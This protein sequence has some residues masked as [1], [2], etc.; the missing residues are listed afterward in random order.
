MEFPLRKLL[1]RLALA[2]GLF[3]LAVPAAANAAAVGINVPGGA[4]AVSKAALAGSTGATTGRVFLI[5]PGGSAPD[6]G[7]VANYQALISSFNANGVKPVIVVTGTTAP[8]DPAAYASYVG[9]LARDYGSSVAAWEI[10]NEPDEAIWWGKSGG[11]PAVYAQ[12]LKDVY[13]KVHP[14]APVFVGGLTGNDYSFLDNLYQALGG[15]SAG[16]FDGVATHTDTA[17]SIAA[18]DSYFRNPDGRISQYSFLGLREVHASMAAHGD[19]TKPIWITELG[20]STSTALCDTGMWAGQKPGGVS[21]SDQ[22]KY[23]LMAWH[24]LKDYPYVTNALWFNLEDDPS[25]AGPGER[26]GLLNPDGSAKPSSAAFAQVVAG[27][28]PYAGQPCGDFTGPTITISS[29][30]AGSAVSGPL[31]IVVSAADASGVGRIT[32]LADGTKIRNFTTGVKDPTQFPKTLNGAITWQHFKYLAPGTH[33]I[34]VV[35]LDAAGNQT[36]Q[37]VQVTKGAAKKHKKH[38][39][40]SHKKH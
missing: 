15:S 35:A 27:Q 4:A 34:Q 30:T 1:V 31:S 11:D 17:C 38:K 18:P 28:D 19:G 29:P 14:Y 3:G 2:A 26:F 13:P 32:L 36:V 21:A 5:Y 40:A 12:V 22:A 16:A 8:A 37:T 20:W 39:K 33:T 9:D 25:G 6:G 7:T 10:W 24:C 23:L